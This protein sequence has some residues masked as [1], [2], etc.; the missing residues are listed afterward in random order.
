M[1]QKSLLNEV[2]TRAGDNN[3]SIDEVMYIAQ[4]IDENMQIFK[5][6][7]KDLLITLDN[8]TD[9]EM[10][11]IRLDPAYMLSYLEENFS[12]KTCK[13]AAD[14]L[15]GDLQ[16]DVSQV[17]SD[18]ELSPS[19]KTFLSN[20]I[21]ASEFVKLVDTTDDA[22]LDTSIRRVSAP[23]RENRELCF[24]DYVSDLRDAVCHLSVVLYQGQ[25]LDLGELL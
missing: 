14:F 8:L 13:Y 3:A 20:L 7:N 23:K 2:F 19:E 5:K 21:I 1:N 18:A 22:E 10:E 9:D 17:V 24:E 6:Q 16:V 25:L 4:E 15:Q 12:N 11:L